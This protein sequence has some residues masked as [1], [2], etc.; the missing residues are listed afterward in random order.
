MPASASHASSHATTVAA[1]RDSLVPA[2]RSGFA[3]SLRAC[4]KEAAPQTTHE[5]AARCG[6]PWRRPSHDVYRN[7][8]G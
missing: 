3:A 4:A 5:A 1:S 8:F 7:V 2:K 6:L